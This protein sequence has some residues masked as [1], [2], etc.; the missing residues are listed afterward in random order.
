[1]VTFLNSLKISVFLL[2]NP[3]AYR[4][5][6]NAYRFW[7]SPVSIGHMPD[8][9]FTF[10]PDVSLLLFPSGS[11]VYGSPCVVPTTEETS[12]FCILRDDL[13]G[14]NVPTPIL[15]TLIVSND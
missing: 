6:A 8:V 10:F 11:P 2:R 4:A 1:M 9:R 12:P 3:G 5:R 7:M 15:Y 14:R 13:Y